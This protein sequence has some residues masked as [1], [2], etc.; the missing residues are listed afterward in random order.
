MAHGV[1]IDD[2][3]SET[4]SALH[5]EVVTSRNEHIEH[6]ST[7][8]D[9]DDSDAGIS[10]KSGGKAVPT[11]SDE[12]EKR[13]DEETNSSRKTKRKMTRVVDSDSEEEK[14]A[15]SDEVQLKKSLFANKDLYDAESSEEDDLPEP[16]YTSKKR[17]S[18]GSEDSG[19][20]EEQVG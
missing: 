19:Q 18:S 6:N 3:A 12:D 1:N 17:G 15:A 20:E 16:G 9:S 4:A 8:V 14:E 5:M 7:L 10:Q 13:K 2:V 11:S